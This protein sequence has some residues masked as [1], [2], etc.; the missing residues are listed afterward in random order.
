MKR[1]R[2][3]KESQTKHKLKEKCE[4]GYSIPPQI[5]IVVK[6][7]YIH[8]ECVVLFQLDSYRMGT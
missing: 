3:E 7:F 6:T 8:V 4:V 2:K 5:P 1:K